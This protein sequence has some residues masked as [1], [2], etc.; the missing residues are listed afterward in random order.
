MSGLTEDTFRRPDDMSN[1]SDPA[2]LYV[3]SYLLTRTVVGIMGIL[4]PLVFILGEAYFL[5]GGVHIRGSL[6]AYYH[7]S[8]RDIFVAG[9]CV[10]GFLLITYM[11]GL[12]RTWDFWLSLVAG[13]AVI[14][15]VFFPTRRPGLSSGAPLCGITPEP[16]GCSPVQ[17]ELG[18]DL[19]AGIHFVSAV[20]F[21][22]G[23]AWISFLFARRE[24]KYR[25]QPMARVQRI[26]GW[27]ILGAV[28]WVILGELLEIEIGEL[29]PLYLGEVISV[30][31]FGVSWLL[32]GL[33]LR[34]LLGLNGTSTAR[35]SKAIQ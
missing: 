9:L 22:L 13:V 18:E 25:S 14:F 19:V 4:L 27:T 33:D 16:A 28:A 24:K 5:K 35:Q 21:I 26:C 31:A 30:W 34:R 7:T 12:T 17:Q 3:R 20:V 15:V 29:T 23:L 6:S 32:K 11:S 8:M 1:R 2:V 10:I